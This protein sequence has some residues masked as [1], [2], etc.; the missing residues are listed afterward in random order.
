MLENVIR[1]QPGYDSI[2]ITLNDSIVITLL[3]QVGFN[4]EEN[5]EY[6]L[7]MIVMAE[8]KDKTDEVSRLRDNWLAGWLY[9]PLR[10][11]WL[12]S[13]HNLDNVVI[14]RHLG[15]DILLAGCMGIRRCL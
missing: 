13:C 5:P 11:I 15:C 3:Y 14:R 1:K 12:T 4:M 8:E 10:R 6:T 7:S 2:V 9:L